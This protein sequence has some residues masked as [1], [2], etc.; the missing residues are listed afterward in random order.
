M[1]PP[2][3]DILIHAG[4]FTMKGR[5]V[6]LIDFFN[7]MGSQPHKHRVAVPGNHDFGI[8]AAPDEW[9]E[10]ARTR[11]VELLID[12]SVNVAGVEIY[13][14][15]ATPRFHDW[16]WNYDRGAEIAKVW[17]RVTPCDILVT[18]G[19]PH[20]IL[21]RVERGNVGCE[22]LVRRVAELRPKMHIFGHIHEGFGSA[23]R[24]GTMFINASQLNGRYVKTNHA[25]L[26]E[27]RGVC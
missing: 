9:T 11:G 8:E 19:P 12:R 3:A 13:G 10:F 24:H 22:E 26:V 7:W 2:E 4:D 25:V 14:S 27:L 23:E 18:H 6:E 16:A 5:D 20:G 15:P 17:D 1:K 21:D